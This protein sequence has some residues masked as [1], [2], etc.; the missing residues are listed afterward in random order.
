MLHIPLKFPTDAPL[1]PW[2]ELQLNIP[3]LIPLFHTLP[4]PPGNP[5]H[6]PLPRQYASTTY[7]RIYANCRLKRIWMAARGDAVERGGEAVKDEWGMY[8]RRL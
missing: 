4:L 8:S 2:L 3:S 6:R 7:I 5:P 1:T